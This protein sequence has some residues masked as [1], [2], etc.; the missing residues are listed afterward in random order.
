M[1]DKKK[2]GM[3]I[4][5]IRMKAGLT[6]SAFLSVVSTTL[7]DAKRVSEW[8]TGVSLPSTDTLLEIALFGGVSL[9]WLVTGVEFRPRAFPSAC[10]D[11]YAAVLKEHFAIWERMADLGCSKFRRM[12]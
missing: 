4:K 9:E 11:D 8:E 2:I 10:I 12:G 7:T 1:V 5:K 6:Q 3:R